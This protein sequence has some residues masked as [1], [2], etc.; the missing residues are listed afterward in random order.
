MS[1]NLHVEGVR[2]AFV[3]VKGKKKTIVDR[4]KFSLWQTPTELTYE[5][6]ALPTIEQKVD[7]YLRWA[8][9]VCPPREEDV[10]DYS[11]PLDENFEYP[12]VGREMVYPAQQHAKELREWLKMCDDECYSVSFYTL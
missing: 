7:T 11:G 3:K 9:S 2:N 8:E 5:V 4:T 12:V 10:Y 6:L 1:M